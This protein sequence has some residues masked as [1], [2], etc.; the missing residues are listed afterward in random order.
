VH[1]IS[2][3][4]IV[5]FFGVCVEG[6]VEEPKGQVSMSLVVQALHS[7]RPTN[8]LANQLNVKSLGLP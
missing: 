6:Y 2:K 4:L 8:S 1:V 3:Q 7:C 5:D